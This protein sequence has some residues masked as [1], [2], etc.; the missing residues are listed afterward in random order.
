MARERTAE[1]LGVLR[2]GRKAVELLGELLEGGMCGVGWHQDGREGGLGG[3]E[4][5]KLLRRAAGGG[6]A[7]G[8]LGELLDG[9]SW[10]RKDGK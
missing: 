4:A 3:G 8:L 7:M 9:G 6:K 5:A 10:G 2:E 1:L